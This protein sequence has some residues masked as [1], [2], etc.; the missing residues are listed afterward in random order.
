M[1]WVD[2]TKSC[3]VVISTNLSKLFRVP[4]K[5]LLELRGF[6]HRALLLNPLLSQE[7]DL[8]LHPLQR[9]RVGAGLFL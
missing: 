4:P 8:G 6:L 2:G 5:D 3:D 7:L 9:F 1:M